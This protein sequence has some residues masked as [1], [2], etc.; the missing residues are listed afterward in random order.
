MD[1]LRDAFINSPLVLGGFIGAVFAA[2]V[3]FI[4]ERRRR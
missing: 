1:F 2:I 3:I 4:A